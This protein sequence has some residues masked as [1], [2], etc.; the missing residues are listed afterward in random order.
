MSRPY[1]SR[2][3]QG[4]H[5]KFGLGTEAFSTTCAVH[6]RR[7]SQQERGQFPRVSKLHTTGISCSLS[8]TLLGDARSV[9]ISCA[10]RASLQTCTTCKLCFFLLCVRVGGHLAV[11]AYWQ[12]TSGSIQRCPGFDSWQLPAFHFSFLSP[13]NIQ[14][15]LLDG[16]I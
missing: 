15:Y 11:V 12:S 3:L 16:V 7:L 8:W 1:F 6:I 2:S 14:I 9:T 4:A 13:H 5:E 10:L